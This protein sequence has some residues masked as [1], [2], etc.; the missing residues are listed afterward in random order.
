MWTLCTSLQIE[1]TFLTYIAI[2]T[3]CQLNAI[4]E[5]LQPSIIIFADCLKTPFTLTRPMHVWECTWLVKSNFFW[6][7][8]VVPPF[9]SNVHSHKLPFWSKSNSSIWFEK[10]RAHL[11]CTQQLISSKKLNGPGTTIKHCSHQS[12]CWQIIA[13]HHSPLPDLCRCET[14]QD[15]WNPTCIGGGGVPP[16]ASN[17]HSHKLPFGSLGTIAKKLNGPMPTSSAHIN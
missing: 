9:A 13:K 4:Y 17:V 1:S 5:T 10:L 12:S 14:V 8:A 15:S 7:G 6:G 3:T 2:P 16:F 11:L